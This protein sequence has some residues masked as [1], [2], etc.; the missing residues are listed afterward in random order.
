[1]HVIMQI[2][3]AMYQITL[4]AAVLVGG[5]VHRVFSSEY[6]IPSY[7]N[8]P[9]YNDIRV[10]F[11]QTKANYYCTQCQHACSILAHHQKASDGTIIE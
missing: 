8:E 9:D 4:I 5:G 1:M 11:S 7:T 6:L 10:S 3:I 2:S